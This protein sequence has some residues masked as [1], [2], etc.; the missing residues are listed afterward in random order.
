MCVKQVFDVVCDQNFWTMVG[1][2]AAMVG[3]IA[4]I[5]A[6]K[7]VFY[8]AKQFK[9]TGWIAAQE[10]FTNTEF[11]KAR[12]EVLKNF[13]FSTKPA[14]YLNDDIKEKALTV[15]RQ[16]DELARLEP[17]LGSKTIIDTWGY[18][19][20]KSW[21]ILEET[22]NEERDSTYHPTKWG[23]FMELGREA[24]KRLNLEELN[25]DQGRSRKNDK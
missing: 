23:A 5:F 4:A 9:F 15:C 20:G 3:A 7:A 25:R 18:P 24:V 1:A 19:L 16:M 11:T 13:P 2:I 14:P 21:M 6:I 8:A 17:Y 22:V 12:T 10:L